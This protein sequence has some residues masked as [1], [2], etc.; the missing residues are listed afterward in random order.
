MNIAHFKKTFYETYNAKN[1]PWVNY[2]NTN[3]LFLG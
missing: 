2:A 3:H 1:E